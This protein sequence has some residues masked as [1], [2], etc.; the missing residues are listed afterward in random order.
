MFLPPKFCGSGM[1]GIYFF[2][3]ASCESLRKIF[4][5]SAEYY[6][7]VTIGLRK[8]FGLSAEYY[9]IVTIGLRKI[10]G[11]SAEHYSIV[12]YSIALL[13]STTQ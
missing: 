4:G 1:K 11:L 10:F 6:S 9:S 8:I 3:F 12:H 7:M 5:L 13:N 2:I